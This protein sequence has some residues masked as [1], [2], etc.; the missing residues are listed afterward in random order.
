MAFAVNK[1][2]RIEKF[3]IHLKGNFIG[4]KFMNQKHKI[5]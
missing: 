5:K 1:Q 2:E 3:P 4:R